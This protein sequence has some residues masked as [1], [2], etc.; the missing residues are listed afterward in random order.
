MKN[1][2]THN[3]MKTQILVNISSCFQRPE[4]ADYILFLRDFIDI[5]TLFLSI[6]FNDFRFFIKFYNFFTILIDGIHSS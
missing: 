3:F 4:Y 6:L 5:K 2:K 1:R